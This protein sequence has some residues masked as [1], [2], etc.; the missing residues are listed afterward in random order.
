M[1]KM[2]EEFEEWQS[3]KDSCRMTNPA[4]FMRDVWSPENYAIV[5]VQYN[6]EAWQASRSAVAQPGKFAEYPDDNHGEY[7]KGYN[8]CHDDWETALGIAQ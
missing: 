1:C 3:K 7:G 6:W 4:W 8:A 2:R 5:R